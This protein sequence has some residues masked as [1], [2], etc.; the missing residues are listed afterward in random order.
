MV[1]LG[2]RVQCRDNIVKVAFSFAVSEKRSFDSFCARHLRKFRCCDGRSPVIVA[3]NAYDGFI[4]LLQ[5]S[6]EPFN[7][8]CED[9][10]G[11]AF[12]GIG[13]IN[14]DLF[15]FLW[16]PLFDY[17]IAYFDG[18]INFRAHE[19][20]W[21]IFI[22]HIS[23]FQILLRILFCPSCALDR[24]IT[25]LVTALVEDNSALQF[26]WRLIYVDQSALSADEGAACVFDQ[27][28]A[29]LRQDLDRHIFRDKF[30]FYQRSYKIKFPLR[31]GREADLDL[32]ESNIHQQ[33]KHL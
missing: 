33:L 29:C 4:A 14:Y 28:L 30:F 1:S 26:R 6:Y 25:H 2:M 20:F 22:S 3:V 10:R 24:E 16:I 7:L 9:I 5:I 15:S 32:F 23:I 31:G 27:V 21:R 12:N 13:K 18:K 19:A 11:R 8:V 17:R